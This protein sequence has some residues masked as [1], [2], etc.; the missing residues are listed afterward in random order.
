MLKIYGLGKN[1]HWQHKTI[2]FTYIKKILIDSIV[3]DLST[4]LGPKDTTQNLVSILYPQWDLQSRSDIDIHK[5]N[6]RYYITKDTMV[7]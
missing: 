6:I 3:C 5:N 1:I 4:V 2:A 7:P